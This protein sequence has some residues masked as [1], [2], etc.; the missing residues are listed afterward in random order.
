MSYIDATSLEKIYTFENLPAGS[1]S[2]NSNGFYEIGYTFLTSA[3]VN[4]VDYSTRLDYYTTAPYFEPNFMT[5]LPSTIQS[6]V[7]TI[8]SSAP[9]NSYSAFFGDVAMIEFSSTGNNAIAIGANTNSSPGFVPAN[10]SGQ[11]NT[12]AAYAYEYTDQII[13]EGHHGDVWFNTGYINGWGNTGEG[14]K[15]FA[16]ILHELGHSLGLEHPTHSSYYDN[17]KYSIMSDDLA[18][19]PDLTTTK[20]PD[21]LQ[22]YDIATIQK[23]YGANYDTR[24]G[25]TEYK[26]GAYQ[27]FGSSTT[28]PVMYSIWDGG[29]EDSID[30]TGV[31]EGVQIDLRQGKFSSIG[32]EDAASTGGVVWDT[33]GY[34]AGNVSIA[35]GAI[36]ENAKGTEE[37]D[38]LIGNAWSNKLYGRGGDD[39]LYGDGVVYV[40]GDAGYGTGVG[41]HDSANNDPP[42]DNND[43]GDD[44]LYGGDGVDN[45]YGG[46]GD[47][48]LITDEF[49]ATQTELNA[50]TVDGG[51]GFDRVEYDYKSTDQAV[52]DI[53]VNAIN[54]ANGEFEVVK[55]YTDAITQATTTFTDQLDHVERIAHAEQKI[56]KTISNYFK[57]IDVAEISGGYVS[58]FLSYAPNSK[59]Y[60]HF[61]RF[62]YNGNEI[63]TTPQEVSQIS[64]TGPQEHLPRV[65]ETS[66]GG[67]IVVWDEW[68]GSDY[69]TLIRKFNSSG[70]SQFGEQEVFENPDPTDADYH[71][72]NNA[73]SEYGQDVAE[74]SNG[75]IAVVSY[76]TGTTSAPF[77]FDAYDVILQVLDSSGTLVGTKSVVNSYTANY[78]RD[79]QVVGLNNGD[80]VVAWYSSTSGAA[81]E[82]V[83][84]QRYTSSGGVYVK[85]GS[86][87]R[88]N[89][90]TSGY[91]DKPDI[92][93]LDDGGFIITWTDSAH[94]G[95]HASD[96]FYSR[97]DASGNIANGEQENRVN[98]NHLNGQ[99]HSSVAALDDG[100]WVITF[101]DH[102]AVSGGS[103]SIVM[104]QQYDSDGYRRGD[105]FM[106][107]VTTTNTNKYSSVTAMD[108]GDFAVGWQDSS[109]D[110]FNRVYTTTDSD[111]VA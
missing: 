25:I 103:G 12:T 52:L 73:S 108:N 86:E 110:L 42:P 71:N 14:T 62:D 89:V 31:V 55:T 68:T 4:T 38:D 66:A 8:L 36:I 47:D 93:A 78:Q 26:Y 104:A 83:F 34:D 98:Q 107:N 6:A 39:A 59:Y 87:T 9:S 37:D 23:I 21:G 2:A 35:F 5:A 64:L 24:N 67:F 54:R 84:F 1:I 69:K 28:D 16:I 19:H 48:L 51:L 77:A 96:V 49:I 72:G 97:Y 22:L 56:E 60:V 27:A 53:Q 90:N 65:T 88:V 17:V 33:T 46:A 57:T 50:N 30:A 61:Q 32:R 76:A 13:H 44:F 29:G 43:S 109:W 58:V 105:N 41:E 94:S 18:V 95:G 82:G 79:P 74:L 70:V 101:T 102:N 63:D 45:L 11:N 3:S 20:F 106:V 75:D 15:Q 10:G 91:Q 7:N 85:A 92:A 100:G 99:D 40:D 81:D 111:A 80:F